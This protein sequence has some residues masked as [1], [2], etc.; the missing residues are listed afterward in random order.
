[1]M[2]E[3]GG[4]LMQ[5]SDKFADKSTQLY[6]LVALHRLPTIRKHGIPGSILGV[7]IQAE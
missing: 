4:P 3:Q 2:H 7:D 5:P 1:M 6:L